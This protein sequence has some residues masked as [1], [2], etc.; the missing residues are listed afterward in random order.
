MGTSLAGR[1]EAQVTPELA[2]GGSGGA[3]PSPLDLMLSPGRQC[4]MDWNCRTPA[5]VGGSPHAGVG[6]R[7]G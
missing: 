7:R 5:R 6:V 1:S 3:E 4:R 2:V